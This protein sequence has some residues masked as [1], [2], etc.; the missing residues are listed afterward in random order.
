MLGCVAGSRSAVDPNRVTGRSYRGY[1]VRV[2]NRL[3]SIKYSPQKT[4]DPKAQC[5]RTTLVSSLATS[6]KSVNV[7]E[8]AKPHAQP[9]R[10]SVRRPISEVISRGDRILFAP[11]RKRNHRYYVAIVTLF[12]SATVVVTAPF[13]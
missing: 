13:M 12:A 3:V 8:V 7:W 2:A 6:T 9:L 11:R 4:K 5:P 10:S 1:Y